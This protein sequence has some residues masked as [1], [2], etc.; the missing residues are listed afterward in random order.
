M[1]S[2]SE[3]FGCL[4]FDDRVMKA[5]LPL[6]VYRSLKK[7]IDEDERLDSEVADAVA[8][9]MKDWAIAH[10]ATHFTHW[11]Q[12]LTGIT[13]EKHDSFI[14]PAPDGGVIMEFSGKELI[15]GEPD[16]SS[17]PSGGLRATFEA[18]GYT[19]WDP[20]SYAFIKDR[21]LCIPTAFCSF[22]GEALDKK[23]P[24]LR[25]MQA[26]NRQ[27]M[28]VLRLFGNTD[29]H[30]VRTSVGP[31]QEYFLVDKEMY[32]RRKDLI[33]CG[34]TLF[35]AKPPKGQELDDHY[36]GVIK[37]RVAAFMAELNEELWKLGVLAKTEHNEVAPSQHELAPIYTTTNIATDHNQ[38]TMEIMQKVALRHGLVCLLHEKPFAGV[39][40]SGKHNNWSMATDT[41]VN[42]LTP[43]DTPYENAQ[44]LLF[45]CAV[46][47]AVDDYQDLLRLSVA[48]AGNDH[49][50]GANEAP[51]AVVSMFL[52]DELTAVLDAIEAD[53]PYS[54][55]EKTVMKLGVHV[56]PKFTR[57]STDRNRTSPFAFTGNKF[58]FRMLGS[59]NSIAC[60][61]IMLN[62]AVA[63]SL[64]Q[65]ADRLEG[66]VD[67]ETALHDLI[68]EVIRAHKRIIFNGNGYDEDWI[69]EATEVRGLLN[70][71][72]TPDA[73][74]TILEKKNVDMLTSLKIFTL[75]EIR[76][77][78][79]I[80]LENYCKTVLIEAETM[81]DM[82][83]KEILPAVERYARVLSDSL[84]AKTAAVPGLAC[85]YERELISRLSAA[86][87]EIDACTAALASSALTV[88]GTENVTAAA[89]LIRDDL[90]PRMAELRVV[91][92][93]A[94]TV[95]DE[96]FWPFPTYG[97][98]LFGV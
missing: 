2:V 26:L 7:T 73:L 8:D 94:E 67:F 29:V 24:L 59:A 50:L 96:S 13:A 35:G 88:R 51:P 98:L 80:T 4:V 52:G 81:V 6:K 15:K 60:T 82:A 68:R 66:A 36:F 62:A 65:Y 43:G 76:S 18:R 56:L 32:D 90:L 3:Y 55:T 58:E 57:D 12:P 16:A 74:P 9:A 63:E 14:S 78:Y 71:R 17:F 61:N 85:R 37:P 23:T 41:G 44:F 10:G 25:S 33:F 47:Q 27:A 79:E 1:S 31:E 46:I 21:T 95:T 89:R 39:N 69:R 72:T 45:L 34:R 40:G 84:L 19:A 97:K 75:P 38:L 86:T 42:L 22:G 28:R 54:G 11:F 93:E 87:D 83:R 49:R 92:D 64:R 20:T 91:C 53:K 30:C 70:L 5:T 48:S 77:R